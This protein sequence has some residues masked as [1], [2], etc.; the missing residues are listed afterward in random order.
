M[1]MVMVMML[2]FVLFVTVVIFPWTGGEPTSR[3]QVLGTNAAHY[4][5]CGGENRDNFD[6]RDRRDRPFCQ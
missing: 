1:V 4:A 3:R 2:A 6:R 5:L